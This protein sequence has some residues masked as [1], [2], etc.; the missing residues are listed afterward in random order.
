[1][2]DLHLAQIGRIEVI[3]PR[4]GTRPLIHPAPATGREAQFSAPYAMLAS[5]NDGGVSFATFT[6]EAVAR[7]SL[8]ER[9]GDVVVT[10][11]GAAPASSEE[12]GA[13]PV[14]IILRMVDGTQRT[15]ERTAA[16]GSADD[17]MTPAQRRAKWID[18][19]QRKT[20]GFSEMA[21][22]SSVAL[23]EAKKCNADL[24]TYDVGPNIGPLNRCI[25]LGCDAFIVPAACDHFSSRALKTLGQSVINWI[26]DWRLISQLA[27][28]EVPLLKGAPRYLGYVLQ[29]FRMYGGE[30]THGH[31]IYARELE[32]ESFASVVSVL[33]NFRRPPALSSGRI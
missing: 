32:K 14:R 19:L 9:F 2:L 21:A 30:L 26:K 4:G 24:I 22:I 7:T 15:F 28:I 10:E 1:M 3:M 23:A 20:R 12:L 31:Q 18:C 13:A 17:P 11:A 6:D 8:R 27:P 16:P 25:L 29:K 5:I 33:R